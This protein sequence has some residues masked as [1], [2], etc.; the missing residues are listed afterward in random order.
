MTNLTD[1]ELQIFT[2]VK[3]LQ[4]LIKQEIQKSSTTFVY[5]PVILQY[6]KELIQTQESCTHSIVKDNKCQICNKQME[7]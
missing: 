2:K 6:N 5:N 1:F 3:E 4:D 7:G